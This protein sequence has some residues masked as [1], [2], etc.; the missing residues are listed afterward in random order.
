MSMK[1]FILLVL[2]MNQRFNAQH[3]DLSKFVVFIININSLFRVWNLY[4][5]D[6]LHKNEILS[7]VI[8]KTFTTK[9]F[10]TVT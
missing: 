8:K 2:V 3:I 4:G 7:A 6:N 1:L 5:Y 9:K 10:V